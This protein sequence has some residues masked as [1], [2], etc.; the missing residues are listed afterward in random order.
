MKKI[1]MFVIKHPFITWLL[2]SSFEIGA[3]SYFF[4]LLN[5]PIWSYFVVDL[6]LMLINLVYVNSFYD[7]LLV[8]ALYEYNYRGNPELLLST[9]TELLN[10]RLPRNISQVNV[11]NYCVAL[12]EIG[13]FR[14]AYDIL[15]TLNMDKSFVLNKVV[16]YNNLCDL[17]HLMDDYD[18]A[19]KYYSEMMSIY[20]N[21]S[22][23]HIKKGFSSNVY[24]SNVNDL[25]RSG[26][27]NEVLL[28]LNEFKPDNLNQSVDT[29]LTYGETYIKLGNY[30]KAKEHLS[31][32]IQ[33]GNKLL[34]VKLA[35]CLLSELK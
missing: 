27:Y 17:C 22:N 20:N 34:N 16:Y 30:D 10:E 15:L 3:L 26:N 5:L 35:K 9:T 6:L 24:L 11:I 21:I 14:E 4:Y 2:M 13:K 31:F 33:K 29:S 19:N 18:N 32:V 1:N 25:Y 12:R 7:S 23:R 8:D 28:K